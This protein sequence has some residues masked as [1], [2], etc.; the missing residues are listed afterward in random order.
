MKSIVVWDLPTRIFHWAL[1][2]SVILALIVAEDRGVLYT[3]H[4]VAGVVALVLVS[5]RL[6]WGFVG[7][8]LPSPE[9]PTPTGSRCGGTP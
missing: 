8:R 9:T 5:F 2:A 7:A 3:V 6:V 4:A 1:T